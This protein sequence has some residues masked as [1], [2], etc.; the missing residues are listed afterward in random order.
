M[1]RK[2]HNPV[3]YSRKE[4]LLIF[5]PFEASN[6]LPDLTKNNAHVRVHG[7]DG[8]QPKTNGK[9]YCKEA[10]NHISSCT[11]IQRFIF[12]RPYVYDEPVMTKCYSNAPE[13]YRKM[14]ERNTMAHHI[15]QGRSISV[16]VHE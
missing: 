3:Y 7:T 12:K 11:P 1:M 5:H 4:Q 6:A 16:E 10:S 2:C 8:N 15:T 14:W 13:I 9:L